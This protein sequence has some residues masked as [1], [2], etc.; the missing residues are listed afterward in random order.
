MPCGGC[1]HT[2]ELR[3]VT[4]RINYSGPTARVRIMKGVHWSL[5]V[6]RAEEDHSRGAHSRH[7]VLHV[8]NQRLLFDGGS[9]NLTI[10]LSAIT[11]FTVYT[12]ALCIE[13]DRGK[14]QVFK[15]VSADPELVGAILGSA[16]ALDRGPA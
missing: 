16:I 8:T 15:W 6:D 7:R 5:R 14:D 3:T 10:R 12:D 11:N 4:K 13:R 2:R 1:G 9:K